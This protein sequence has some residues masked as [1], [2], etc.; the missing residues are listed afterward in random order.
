MDDI[1]IFGD[2][3]P[4]MP[5]EDYLQAIKN[6]VTEILPSK[7]LFFQVRSVVTDG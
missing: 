1:F 6:S 7:D 5:A 3:I 4:T 2:A